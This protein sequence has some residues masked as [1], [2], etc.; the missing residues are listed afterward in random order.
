[1]KER[2]ELKTHKW[3]VILTTA[4]PMVI[5]L[6][7]VMLMTLPFMPIG[8]SLQIGGILVFIVLLTLLFCVPMYLGAY[9][10][11]PATQYKGARIIA[12]LG[13]N[14]NEIAGVSAG[15]IIVKQNF[16]EKALHVCHV[17]Q[18]GTMLYF[19]G[20]PEVAQVRD[21]I[22]ANF[23]EKTAVMR[24]IEEKERKSRKKKK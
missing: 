8:M 9:L 24:S 3:A 14:E 6:V 17:R 12:R 10:F 19:R 4:W 18:K 16:I 21:W 5:G 15:E 20:V 23:P 2:L 7:I 13:R 1:M 11:L 22:A